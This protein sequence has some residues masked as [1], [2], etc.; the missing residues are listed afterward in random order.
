[1]CRP[2]DQ[3]KLQ[4]ADMDLSEHAAALPAQC[5]PQKKMTRPEQQEVVT[6][7]MQKSNKQSTAAVCTTAAAAV[8]AT[9]GPGIIGLAPA[10][11]LV[12]A[13]AGAGTS[14][15]KRCSTI[16]QAAAAL[17]KVAKVEGAPVSAA[18]AAANGQPQPATT[19]HSCSTG[20]CAQTSPP[21]GS[22]LTE[23]GLLD[24]PA[25]EAT[26][27]PDGPANRLPNFRAAC[28]LR[29]GSLLPPLPS[30]ETLQE[31]CVKA[32]AIEALFRAAIAQAKKPPEED[33][34]QHMD[35]LTRELVALHRQV[36][37]DL[38][39]KPHQ[40]LEQIRGV[41]KSKL[42]T[43]SLQSNADIRVQLLSFHHLLQR[44]CM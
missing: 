11:P 19:W 12:A 42:Q 21:P 31:M 30:L 29:A 24:Q 28:F 10:R 26:R 34:T 22:H 14:S 7:T 37:S 2:G 15:R 39:Q 38:F 16:V 35:P 43:R 32:A 3:L 8:A 13:T 1:M 33:D 41:Q 36:T 25:A 20:H 18:A 6:V 40:S 17:V 5:G 23:I 9:A 44:C 27:V 4:V